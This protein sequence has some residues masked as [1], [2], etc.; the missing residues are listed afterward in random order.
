MIQQPHSWTFIHKEENGLLWI[1]REVMKVSKRNLTASVSSLLPIL[2]LW[3]E[4]W[5]CLP[6]DYSDKKR[7]RITSPV[8]FQLYYIHS[9]I[10]LP[11]PPGNTCWKTHHLKGSL[12]LNSLI[13]YSSMAARARGSMRVK[14]GDISLSLQG[15]LLPLNPSKLKMLS[16]IR[17][18]DKYSAAICV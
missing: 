5:D 12:V 6:L 4:S 18:T 3:C 14:R 13:W 7:K 16:L 1:Y 17:T 2:I 15:S 10:D 8:F 11:A 9:W